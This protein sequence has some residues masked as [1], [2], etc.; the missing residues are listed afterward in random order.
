MR[1]QRAPSQNDGPAA[2]EKALFG[3]DE[4]IDLMSVVGMLRRR[5]WLILLVTAI[6]T[7]AAA[8]LGMQKTPEY[9]AQAS[10]M[11]DPRQLQVTNIEQV[12]TGMPVTTA[13]MATQIGLLRSPSFLANVMDDLT[14][15]D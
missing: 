11:V 6:G 10:V 7:A 5:K 15:F 2:A 1:T 8:L 12:L 9:T 4:T 3:D 14:L 13:T